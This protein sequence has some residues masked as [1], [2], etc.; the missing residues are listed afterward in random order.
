MRVALDTNG[1][2]TTHA[3]VAR[4]I[5]GLVNGLR[6][7]APADLEPMELAWEVENFEYRQPQ[8]L[9]KTA[10]RELFWAKWIAPRLLSDRKVD[11]LHSTAGVLITPPSPMKHVATLNDLA[12]LR[13]PER[14]RW[15]Q[16]WSTKNRLPELKK[17]DRIICISQFT[18]DEATQLLELP[19]SRLEVIYPG[20]D[21]HPQELPPVEQKPDFEIPSD[22]F[23]FV[24]SLEPGKNLALLKESYRLAADK[25]ESLQPLLIVGARW[26]GVASEGSQPQ[27]W[28]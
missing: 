2:F 7:V 20:C 4:Y 6:Q 3:G 22:F 27:G 19:S 23:L 13:F 28:H 21:F 15:W 10:Y 18:A 5:R 9:L 26:A 25:R 8:R 24:G 17:V 1:L 11:L 12:V 14:F 16:R